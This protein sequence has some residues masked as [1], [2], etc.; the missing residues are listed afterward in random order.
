M[1]IPRP[2]TPTPMT[3]TMIVEVEVLVLAFAQSPELAL[4][5]LAHI[6]WP[7]VRSDPYVTC[8]KIRYLCK[9]SVHDT[10]NYP[11]PKPK[12]SVSVRSVGIH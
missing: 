3:I 4:S 5:T 1:E 10:T 9:V 12:L 11:K 6:Q 7:I 2:R 8:I